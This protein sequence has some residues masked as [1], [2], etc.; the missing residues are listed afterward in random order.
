ML[1][2]NLHQWNKAN[3]VHF[4]LIGF[5]LIVAVLSINF[6]FYSAS[7]ILWLCN[8][9]ALLAGVALLLQMPQ[10]ALTGAT[11]MIIGFASW[12]VNAMFNQ[13]FTEPLSCIKHSVYALLGLLTFFQFR[14]GRYLW[15]RSFGW[16][17]FTQ[18]LSRL[19]SSPTENINLAF[20][21]WQGWDAFFTNFITFWIFLSFSCLLLLFIANTIIFRCQQSKTTK[22]GEL[23][24]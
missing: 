1:N 19:F 14:V 16:Y 24:I 4:R 18:L 2:I 23:S 8:I 12:L 20:G 6:F 5:L 11:F 9:S 15:L 3:S 10:L 21:V 7:S 22:H 17:L 13:T